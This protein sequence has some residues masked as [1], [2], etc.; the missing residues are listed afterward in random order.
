MT[1]KKIQSIDYV[2]SFLS[3]LNR[4]NKSHL[5]WSLNFT[6]KNPLTSKLISNLVYLF[7]ELRKY[8]NSNAN[9]KYSKELDE[10]IKI[11]CKKW[12]QESKKGEN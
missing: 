12:R 2:I 8:K 11:E 9:L 6:S 1:S 4:Y 3:K 7:E 5:W 10:K